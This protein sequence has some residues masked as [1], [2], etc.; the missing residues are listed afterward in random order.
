G[1]DGDVPILE[2]DC[3]KSWIVPPGNGRYVLSRTQTASSWPTFTKGRLAYEQKMTGLVPPFSIYEWDSQSGDLKAPIE[4]EDPISV[5]D[6]LA[7]LGYN[8][9]SAQAGKTTLV[10]TWWRIATPPSYQLS[11]MVHLVG[12]DGT[13]IAV[14]DGL[15]TAVDQWLTGSLLIQRHL[16]TVPPDTPPGSYAL[17][18]GA[19]T[20]PELTRLPVVVGGAPSEDHVIAGPLEVNAP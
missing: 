3:D 8:A 14:G 11:L 19:Y 9:Q 13:P 17:H 2:F 18:I 5:G 15:G 1:I 6:S 16:L 12:S 20:F 7:L 10:E 4:F